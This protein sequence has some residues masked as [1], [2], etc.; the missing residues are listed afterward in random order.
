MGGNI[1]NAN[2]EL[3]TIAIVSHYDT[4]SLLPTY[5][6]GIG[7][8]GSGTIAVLEIL[9]FMSHLYNYDENIKPKYH[10]LN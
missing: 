3:P 8:S 5:G 7:S 10:F 9:R 1:N 2:T 6:S 4:L